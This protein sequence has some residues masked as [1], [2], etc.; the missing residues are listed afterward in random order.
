M[1]DFAY[2]DIQDGFVG[3]LGVADSPA[4]TNLIWFRTNCSFWRG[5]ITGTDATMRM[6]SA[7]GAGVGLMGVSVDGAAFSDVAEPSDGVFQLFSGLAD[8]DHE[9]IVTLSSQGFYGPNYGRFDITPSDMITVNG[10]APAVTTYSV[11]YTPREA[12]EFVTA[13][14]YMPSGTYSPSFTP[15][16]TIYLPENFSNPED[17]FTQSNGRVAFR[18]SATDIY[19]LT[20]A[21]GDIYV[22]VDGADATI[23]STQTN[24][25]Q[26]HISSDGNSHVFYIWGARDIYAVGLNAPFEA[27]VIHRM[28]R[29]G[30]SISAGLN[31]S[32]S[33][34][35]INN[36]AAFF[37]RLGNSYAGGGWTSNTMLTHLPSLLA[38]QVITAND[39]ATFAIGRNNVPTF[40]AQGIA[41]FISCIDLLVATAYG[42]IIVEG[43]APIG[44]TF[45]DINVQIEQIVTDYDNPRVVYLDTSGWT[46]IEV[47]GGGDVTHPSD[48]GYATMEAY[49]KIDYAPLLDS[50]SS[51]LGGLLK[52][53]IHSNIA[54]SISRTI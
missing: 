23:I 19:V 52:N 6:G 49:G 51:A 43:V 4:V 37:G 39:V 40:D 14:G 25:V 17:S 42:L 38:G 47:V 31:G 10:A 16:D 2:A 50:L 22:S 13:S 21:I 34:V 36:I 26:A 54:S 1:A 27:Q 53:A 3:S 8:Q 35:A 18:T 32:Q 5:V 7:F 24:Q 11:K 28:D 33:E 30:D 46:G 29:Y 15:T 12:S 44:A 48:N 9:V 45:N 41:D 20:G